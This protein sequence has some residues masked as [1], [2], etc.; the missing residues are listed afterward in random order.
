MWGIKNQMKLWQWNCKSLPVTYC[1]SS[2]TQFLQLPCTAESCLFC[3]IMRNIS[4]SCTISV[5]V[6]DM[7]G[8]WSSEWKIS[9]QSQQLFGNK[10]IYR[11][12]TRKSLIETSLISAVESLGCHPLEAPTSK[13]T[14]ACNSV[15]NRESC[16]RLLSQKNPEYFISIS[17]LYF[18]LWL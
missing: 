18:W 3:I 7:T 10:Q 17:L 9:G 16:K 14:E 11:S 15:T 8:C 5:N 12:T 6:E 1:M 13:N 4:G 2:L